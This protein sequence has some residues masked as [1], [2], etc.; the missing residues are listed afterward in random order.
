MSSPQGSASR[1]NSEKIEESIHIQKDE[2]EIM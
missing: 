1:A 2:H